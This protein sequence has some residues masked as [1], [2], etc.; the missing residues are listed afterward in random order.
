MTEQQAWRVLLP[1]GSGISGWNNSGLKIV[2]VKGSKWNICKK[3]NL[4]WS[5]FVWH[6]IKYLKLKHLKQLLE[7]K[8]K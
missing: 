6:C 1:V 2:W 4:I 5:L 7:Q 8:L 3:E